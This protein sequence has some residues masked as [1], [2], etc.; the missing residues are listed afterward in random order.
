MVVHSISR[1]SRSI[2]D[3]D[4]TVEA[5]V[6]ES[7]AELHIISEGTRITGEEDP[8]QTAMMQLLGVFASSKLK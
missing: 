8:Y 3:L 2:R 7:G 1:L 4:Q 5:I 6:E